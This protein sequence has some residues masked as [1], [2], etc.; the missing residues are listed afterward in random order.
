VIT[1]IMLMENAAC[2]VVGGISRIQATIAGM[3]C[4]SN[5]SKVHTFTQ[6]ATTLVL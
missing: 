6:D 1:K 3:V 4:Q 2:L 5:M